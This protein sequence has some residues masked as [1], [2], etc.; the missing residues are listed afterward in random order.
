MKSWGIPFTGGGKSIPIYFV[1][2]GGKNIVSTVRQTPF[3]HREC[4]AHK[5][6]LVVEGA[7]NSDTSAQEMLRRSIVS[8]YYKSKAATARLK[9]I[10]INR[11]K[12][13]IQMVDT[14]WNSESHMLD[15]LVQLKTAILTELAT[16]PYQVCNMSND[17][18]DL[19]DGY[20]EAL[21]SIEIITNVMSAD[22]Y[23][24]T[25][26]VILVLNEIETN[27]NDITSL[28]KNNANKAL[29]I[30]LFCKKPSPLSIN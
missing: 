22:A 15:R 23:P 17:E 9:N 30:T 19:A 10:Q 29:K 13:I 27:L 5:L 8:H 20:L 4:F 2:D 18:W 1:T 26:I 7:V 6:Q 11:P 25:S 24:T 16:S 3:F 21:K 12:T 14:R 28:T